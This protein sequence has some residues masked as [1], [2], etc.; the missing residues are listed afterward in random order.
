ME[1]EQPNLNEEFTTPVR[2]TEMVDPHQT[3]VHPIWRTPSGRDLYEKINFSRPL[4]NPPHTSVTT[5]ADAGPSS[6]YTD[7]PVDKQSILLPLQDK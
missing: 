6:Q 7:H 3:H 4:F 2:S 1:P 5:G